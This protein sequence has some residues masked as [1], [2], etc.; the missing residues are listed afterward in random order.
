MGMAG[1]LAQPLPALSLHLCSGA[2]ARQS[3]HAFR[4]P[5]GG[6]P[7]EQCGGCALLKLGRWMLL[8][9]RQRHPQHHGRLAG[10]HWWSKLLLA[11]FLAIGTGDQGYMGVAWGWQPQLT[12]QPC[13][14]WGGVQQVT[15]AHYVGDPLP[16]IIDHDSQ[17]V[18]K[19][20]VLAQQH[21]VADFSGKILP[22]VALQ[23]VNKLLNGIRH[24]A[25]RGAG[26]GNGDRQGA[27]GSGIDRVCCQLQ[28]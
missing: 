26:F 23:A 4:L 3:L 27:T 12:L 21:E 25:T 13:L 9:Q 14:A 17:L 5:V 11:E 18:G 7:I 22:E 28:S 20:A 24:P 10:I 1:I 19:Q 8:Q 15:A 16:T 6:G 2:E